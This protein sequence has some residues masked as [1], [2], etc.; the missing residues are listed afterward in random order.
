MA[1]KRVTF[2]LRMRAASRTVIA[3]YN[4]E[5]IVATSKR[6]AWVARTKQMLPP[7]SSSPATTTG[8][9][10]VLLGSTCWRLSKILMRRKRKETVLATA[11]GQKM[12]V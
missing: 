11:K 1:C 10:A 4:E 8:S 9:N 5:R 2:S 3:G 6:P 7:A 12:V